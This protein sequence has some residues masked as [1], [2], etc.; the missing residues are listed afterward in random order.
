MQELKK[1]L[2][3]TFLSEDGRVPEEGVDQGG[4]SREFFQLLV[5]QL[6]NADYG[7]FLYVEESRVCWFNPA[8]MESL[9]RFFRAP[10]VLCCIS[11]YSQWLVF[12]CL[13]TCAALLLL[14][15]MPSYRMF[16]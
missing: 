6:F 1:P 4:V 7:M 5:A 9:V 14:S 12:H 2:R 3:V 8:S 10:H 15:F 16:S 13:W 11:T